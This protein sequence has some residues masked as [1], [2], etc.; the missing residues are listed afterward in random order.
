MMTKIAKS[1]PEALAPASR[2]RHE[3]TYAE[4]RRRILDGDLLPY[5]PLSEYQL[6]AELKVSRTPVREALKRLEHE[7]LVWF[8][9]NRGAFVSGF[10]V[11][12]IV[13]IYQVREQLEGFCARVA[14]SEMSDADIEALEREIEN[15]QQLAAAGRVS[16]TFDSDVHLH[17]RLIECAKN[18]RLAAIL[19]TLDDQVHRIRVLSPNAPGRIQATLRE[20]HDI[21]DCLRLHDG[22]GAQRAMVRHLRAACENAILMMLPGAG[23]KVPKEHW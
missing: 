15:A 17:K 1:G 2:P 12:D 14:A 3:R 22:E 11:A 20:H 23:Q 6:A 7:G 10:S 18:G 9:L 19:S 4:I 13:E 16:E 8:V 5:E 21:L